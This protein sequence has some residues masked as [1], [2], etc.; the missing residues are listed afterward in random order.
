MFTFSFTYT[1]LSAHR[2]FVLLPVLMSLP[3]NHLPYSAQG[4]SNL[5]HTILILTKV[6][7]VY[8]ISTYLHKSSAH[9]QVLT[10]S[11]KQAT[12]KITYY[13]I[14]YYYSALMCSDAGR[15]KTFG[16]PVVIGG[17]NLPPPVG[18]GL[19]DLRKSGPTPWSLDRL[20]HHRL[21]KVF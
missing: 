20:I 11:A 17:A 1:G 13:S 19:T 8:C 7:F 10:S 2:N 6:T 21:K 5:L 9:K 15:G 3:L 4:I 18:I 14:T 16:V 12:G